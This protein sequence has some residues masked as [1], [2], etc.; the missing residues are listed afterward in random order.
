LYFR[1]ERGFPRI[2]VAPRIGSVLGFKA[3]DGFFVAQIKVSITAFS[4]TITCINF[5]SI[6]LKRQEGEIR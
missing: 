3:Q 6:K 2:K 4:T 5:A 1:K